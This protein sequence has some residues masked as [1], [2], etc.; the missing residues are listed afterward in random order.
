MNVLRSPELLHRSSSRLLLVDVQEKLVAVLEES[1][2]KSLLE[3]CRFLAQGARAMGIPV[4]ATEHYPQGLGP[5]VSS[6]TEFT[7]S[8]PAKKRFSAFECSGLPT[9]A[10]DDRFQVVVAGMETH[11]CVRQ[12]TRHTSQST[13]SRDEDQSTM[14]WRCNEWRILEL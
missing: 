9:A 3:A 12:D 11:V 8:R 2:Q 4:I 1:I 14:K 7:N 6:L 13:P 10:E 5:T